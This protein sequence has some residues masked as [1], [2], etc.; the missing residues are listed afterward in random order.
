[1]T[2]KERANK[3]MNDMY[4]R[5]YHMKHNDTKQCALIAIDLVISATGDHT[6]NYWEQVKEE[7]EKL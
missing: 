5:T 2:P 4:Q 7:I 3:L 6:T 1:M